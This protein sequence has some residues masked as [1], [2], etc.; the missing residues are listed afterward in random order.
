MAAVAFGVKVFHVAG[1]PCLT[2]RRHQREYTRKMDDAA[3]W[4][5]YERPTPATFLAGDLTEAVAQRV[6]TEAFA[7]PTERTPA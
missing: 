6:L 4:P 2:C 1:V 7:P 3:P 5:Y